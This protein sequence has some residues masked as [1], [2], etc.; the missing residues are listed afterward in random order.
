VSIAGP[1]NRME[2]KLEKTAELLIEVCRQLE[3]PTGAVS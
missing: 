2:Q 1:S 3:A